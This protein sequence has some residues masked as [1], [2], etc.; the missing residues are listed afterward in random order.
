MLTLEQAKESALFAWL[1]AQR[2][3]QRKGTLDTGTQQR[4]EQLLSSGALPNPGK[5]LP[6]P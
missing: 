2:H 1:S 3:K 4:L 6:K 5:E